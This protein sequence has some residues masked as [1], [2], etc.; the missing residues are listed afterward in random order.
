MNQRARE[1][2]AFV[3]GLAGMGMMGGG[4]RNSKGQGQ[5][6]PSQGV[7]SPPSK[8]IPPKQTVISNKGTVIDITPS[9]T[10]STSKTNLGLNG[11]PNSSVDILDR[12]GN[13]VTR[14]WFDKNGRQIRD[15]DFTQHRNPKNHPEVPHE[16]G[17]RN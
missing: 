7:T 12:Q 8:N 14:R 17:P 11:V 5:Q 6:R 9:Q 10:H 13:L 15:V 3:I 16:H 1:Q 2:A 4:N